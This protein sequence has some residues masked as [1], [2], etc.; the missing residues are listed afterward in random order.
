MELEWGSDVERKRGRERISGGPAA[1]DSSG[2]SEWKSL[3]LGCESDV[4]RKRGRERI[5]G[6]P[7]ATDS[8]GRS[9]LESLDLGCESDVEMKGAGGWPAPTHAS[10]SS[11]SELDLP[12]SCSASGASEADM[13]L[14]SSDES[15]RS[16]QKAA[17]MDLGCESDDETGPALAL[18]GWHPGK[19]CGISFLSERD[20]P[21]PSSAQVIVTNL[22]INLRRLPKNV[23]QMILAVLAPRAL[24][25][26]NFA[27]RAAAALAGFSHSFARR[28]H[29][30]VR[31]NGWAPCEADASLSDAERARREQGLAPNFGRDAGGR[32]KSSKWALEV[33][34][35]EA[36]AVS[37]GGACDAEYV[38][39]MQRLKRHGLSLGSKYCTAHIVET[40]ELLAVA[41]ARALA[42]DELRHLIPSLG[43]PSDLVLIFDGVSIGKSSFSRHES[44]LLIGFAFMGQSENGTHSLVA[45]LMAAP[46]A[47]QAHKGLEQAELILQ[48]LAEHPGHFTTSKLR[49]RLAAVGGDGA[50]CQG[51][52]DSVHGSAGVCEILC[53]K[54][55]PSLPALTD[56]DLFHRINIAV[57]K[58][59]DD[60]PCAAEVFEVALSLAS[61]FGVGDGRVIYRAVAD[62]IG[63]KCLRVPDQGGSRKVVALAAT[64]GHLVKN[65]K[66]FIAGLHARI[67][68][69][70]GPARRGSQTKKSLIKTGRRVS[71][72]NFVTFLVAM[73]DVLGQS[74]VP[75][76]LK[77]QKVDISA[78]QME[79]QCRA[80]RA[81]FSAHRGHLS[82]LRRWCFLSSLLQQMLSV[83]DLEHLWR[84]LAL[85]WRG[86][87]RLAP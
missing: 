44:L 41:A 19:D 14:S 30:R 75:L 54:V 81:E 27:D 78:A 13:H 33:R 34:V 84:A 42:S 64:V 56:W 68:Q 50:A 55:H 49:A 65:L 10:A 32:A 11:G 86:F 51:G 57:V 76:A 36:L 1:T 52:E 43:I 77:S 69:A 73:R 48:V 62:E 3:G 8:S 16:F 87:S 18:G 21:L 37:Q 17:C 24:V 83:R 35:R 71:A 2:R 58:A 39:A 61:L 79:M 9:D 63:E 66:S 28:V 29:D 67:G 80:A 59:V 25:V 26:R 20:A 74:V 7:A 47:G 22:Y 40:V 82:Q 5:R 23:C 15:G 4:E 70:E 31:A 12:R 45:R 72:L 60:T 38:A 85:S 6:G 53:E 46:S